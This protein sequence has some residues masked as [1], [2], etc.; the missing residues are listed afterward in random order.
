MTPLLRLALSLS[1]LAALPTAAGAQ[2]LDGDAPDVAV[3]DLG[4]PP[5]PPLLPTSPLD[6]LLFADRVVVGQ[7]TSGYPPQAAT[8]ENGFIS[9]AITGTGFPETFRFQ[10]PDNYNAGGAGHP[11]VV[12][13]HGFGG[14]ANTPGDQ[15]TIDEECNARDWIYMAP[16]G[17]DDKLFGSPISQQNTEAAMQW[18]LDN[19]NVDPDRIYM[20]GFSMGGGVVSNFAARRRDPDGIMIAAVGMV[21]STFDWVMEYNEGFPALHDWLSNEF[22][23]GGAP[24]DDIFPYHQASGA[25]FNEGTYP[26]YPGLIIEFKTMINNLGDLP[27]YIT[28]D[29]L[30]ALNRVPLINAQL[31]ATLSAQGF[32][33]T[34]RIHTGTV[35]PNDGVTLVPHSW[36][37]LDEVEMFN[38]FDGKVVDRYPDD[39]E[40]ILDLGGPVGWTDTDQIGAGFSYANGSVDGVADTVVLDEVSNIDNLS[41]DGGL[42]GLSGMPQV[43]ATSADARGFSL[44]L[45]AMPQSPSY[46]LDATSGDVIPGV[47]SDPFNDTLSVIVPAMGTMDFDVISDPDWTASFSSSPNPVS[48]GTSSTVSID[49]V[50]GAFGAWIIVAVEEELLKL[51]GVNIVAKPVPPALLFFVPLDANGDTSFPA[52]IPNEPTF[53]GV[54]L[55]TQAVIVDGSQVP[56]EVTNLW[57]FEID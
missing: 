8:I 34:L 35:D 41:V 51:K 23:F 47:E 40:A 16:T 45:E 20:V 26:P 33:T 36:A 2:T 10:I 3:P 21:C 48:I 27:F 19:Y 1:L 14:S 55:P 12:A 57:G 7:D 43:T 5:L 25:Y 56:L 11:M 39:F 15:S 49:A 17:I 50:S 38:Y 37:V 30:D 22:N 24:V 53:Q 13:Y 54:R 28:F 32:D 31:E 42:A 4:L 46:L 29:T 9:S 44:H 6:S 52:N 18:M